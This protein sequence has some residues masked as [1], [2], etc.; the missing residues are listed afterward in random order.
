M[1]RELFARNIINIIDVKNCTKFDVFM[2]EDIKKQLIIYLKKLI[3][4]PG[5]DIDLF[6][7]RNEQTLNKV[8]QNIKIDIF[9]YNRF[10]DDLKKIKRKYLM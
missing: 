8:A 1:D 6:I 4:N 10:M 5:N 7:A 2:N 3:P 9:E